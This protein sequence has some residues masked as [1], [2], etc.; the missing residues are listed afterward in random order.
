MPLLHTY[1]DES[2]DTFGGK[3]VSMLTLTEA[4]LLPTTMTAT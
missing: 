2:I 1:A 3:L 4:R